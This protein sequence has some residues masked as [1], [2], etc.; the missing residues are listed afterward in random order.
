[1]PLLKAVLGAESIDAA[2]FGMIDLDQ[3][4]RPYRVTGLIFG[5]AVAAIV[6]MLSAGV[7]TV[8]V[9]G[10]GLS[11]AWLLQVTTRPPTPPPGPQTRQQV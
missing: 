8:V 7:L 9:I 4:R 3:L 1:M 5:V 10:G 2:V 11:L 6:G